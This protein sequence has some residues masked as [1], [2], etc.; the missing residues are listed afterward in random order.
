MS[1]L[2]PLS[3]NP[4]LCACVLM[5]SRQAGSIS[6][7]KGVYCLYAHVCD[8]EQAGWQYEQGVHRF[9]VYVHVVK[10]ASWQHTHKGGVLRLPIG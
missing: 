2:W 3:L 1:V 4:S 7:N 9:Y 10:Q 5:W 6:M 8:E